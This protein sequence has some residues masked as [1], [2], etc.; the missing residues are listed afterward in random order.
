MP[1]WSDAPCTITISLEDV[2][3]RPGEPSAQK[4]TAPRGADWQMPT[5]RHLQYR[6][7]RCN[8]ADLAPASWIE[9]RH[10]IPDCRRIVG[11]FS[12]VSRAGPSWKSA[13]RVPISELGRRLRLRFPPAQLRLI[14]LS[15]YPDADI[16]DGC[17]AAGRA[18][19]LVKPGDIQE[20]ERLLGGDRADPDASHH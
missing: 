20:L 9:T 15:G 4:L 17:V 12:G 13:R 16:R 7:V 2:R 1:C 14:A 6:H 3:V 10:R 8:R 18:A 5:C 11:L 19:Y